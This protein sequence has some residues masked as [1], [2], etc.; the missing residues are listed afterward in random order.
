MIGVDRVVVH[1]HQAMSRKILLSNNGTISRL[2]DRRTHQQTK[3][4]YSMHTHEIHASR[5][6]LPTHHLAA[7]V[8]AR[9]VHHLGLTFL[10][11]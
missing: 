9:K 4:R 1:R 11:H 10:R 2:E 5:P 7:G 8:R 6:C 3:R